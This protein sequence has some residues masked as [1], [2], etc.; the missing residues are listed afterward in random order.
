MVAILFSREVQSVPQN[1]REPH[2]VLL[3]KRMA[4]KPYNPL[5][6]SLNPQPVAKLAGGFAFVAS[7]SIHVRNPP[8]AQIQFFA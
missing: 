3:D 8:Q 6:V 7:D 4:C 5:I 2:V 1:R